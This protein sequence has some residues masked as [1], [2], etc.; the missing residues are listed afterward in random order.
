MAIVPL[1]QSPVRTNAL[2]RAHQIALLSGQNY[3][4]MHGVPQLG[5]PAII[6]TDGP[7]G[8]RK[9]HANDDISLANNVPATCF[10]TASALASSWDPELVAAVAAAIGREARAEG[11]S[12]VLGP[13]VNIKRSPLGGRNF[14]YFSE[15]PFLSSALATRYIQG[16]QSTGVAASL[17]HFAANNQEYRRMTINAVVDERAL[18]EL[19]LASFE[20]AVIEG[21]PWTV[22]CA[23]NS[24]NGALASQNARLL[25]D[26]LR[27]EWGYRGAIISDWGA[28]YDRVAALQ[29][30]LDLE[31]PG[32]ANA[33]AT[34]ITTALRAGTLSA[35]TIDSAVGHLLTLLEQVKPAYDDPQPYDPAAHHA[36]AR[37]AASE[38]IVLLKNATQLLPLK[39][40]QRIALIGLFA[41]QPR[42]Q[43]AGSSRITPTVIDTLYD[44][45]Q[46][47][48]A[49]PHLLTYA[50]GYTLRKNASDPD[51]LAQ[52]V[53]I[54]R[55]ADVVVLCIG[56]PDIAETEGLDRLHMDLPDS[57]NELVDAVVHV[58]PNVVVVL[59][60]GAPVV[61]PWYNAVP[62]IV[63]AYLAG[64][65]SGSALADIL[66]GTVNPSGK[67]AETFPHQWHDNPT[68]LSFPGTPHDVEYRES[69]Y[70]GYRYY[71]S[72]K[73]TVLFP[74]G[75]GKSYT[76]FAYENL[77]VPDESIAAQD[78]VS[79]AFDLINTGTVAGSEVVQIYVHDNVST[80]FR[81]DQELKA[82]RKVH[83]AA[84]ERTT[85]MFHLPWRAFAAFDD[86]VAAWLVESGR[87]EIRVGASSRDI[88]CTAVVDLASADVVAPL[89][90]PALAPYY[91]L[92]H[93]EF[94]A[95]AFHA[96]LGRPPLPSVPRR[97]SYT[98]NTPI[99]D[100]HESL[101]G[102]LIHRIIK[103]QLRT[104]THPDPGG[105][106]ELL[107]A[108]AAEE[109]PLRVAMT[110]SRGVVTLDHIEWLLAI[111]NGHWWA[112]VRRIP[113][114]FAR[115][116]TYQ[117][118]H[119]V[120][121]TSPPSTP[122]P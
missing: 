112:A 94:P 74:F 100:M 9:Q 5:L 30:G 69:L 7:H 19:Y 14:E 65:A 104:M 89:N 99:V 44:A 46:Q 87:F 22:M 54:A 122:L 95:E 92:D 26:I 109:I 116:R 28:V 49:D 13:G 12:V 113:R 97:G 120:S 35:A 18:R 72:A 84:G 36:L 1:P 10:P 71:D 85:M 114:L 66:D 47:R 21:Q 38:S 107:F 62:T 51:L 106:T 8:L 24:V 20:Q 27:T 4:Q 60:N 70:V 64:Q 115:N 111:I 88:R 102:R 53:E 61:M 103:R 16:M 105:P 50:P 41:Q 108:A 82:F 75:H 52:A 83:L 57:H 77:R 45:L 93:A 101:L 29:A 90:N 32:N 110:F 98:I 86:R 63:E 15:D 25:T 23:Y 67:L 11:V 81:P 33:H 78:G 117:V 73:K 3:W 6:L 91:D 40:R 48:I 43:G 2:S 79:L 56:L 118:I 39:P 68:H 119:P 55:T 80:L 34:R 58:N 121:R 59:S 96:L 37:Q 31:M 42:Y 76:T 17:K